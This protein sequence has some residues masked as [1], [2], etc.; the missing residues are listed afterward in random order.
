MTITHTSYVLAV[1]NLARASAYWREVLGFARQSQPPGWDFLV[2][3]GCRVMLGEC[4]DDL[5]PAELGSHGYFGY[6]VVDDVDALHA[7]I[8]GRGA[9]VPNPPADK[10]WGMR[11]MVVFTPDGHRLMFAQEL[12]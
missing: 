8:T 9:I 10:P 12:A 1:P 4:P 2:R 5:P 6:L 3:D 11:E 7:E